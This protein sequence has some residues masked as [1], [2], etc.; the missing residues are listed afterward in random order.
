MA[1]LWKDVKTVARRS[2]EDVARHKLDD[3][4]TR[5]KPQ[6]DPP[7]A[8]PRGF[9]RGGRRSWCAESRDGAVTNVGDVLSVAG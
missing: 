5:G 2:R 7:Q 4:A 9:G 8:E 1:F 6:P 3:R